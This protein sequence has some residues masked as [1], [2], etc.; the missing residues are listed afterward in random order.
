MK[1][2][3]IYL[4]RHGQTTFNVAGKFTGWMDP[5]LTKAGV[6]DAKIVARKLRDKKFGIAIHTRLKRSR[7]TLNEV[8]KFHTECG[9]IIEDDR[10]IERNYGDLNGTTHKQFIKRIGRKL[11]DLEIEGDLIANL[12]R[13]A[14][15]EAEKFLGE[16]EFELVHRGFYVP[17]P[18][19]ESFSDVEKRV[20]SFIIDLKKM[21]KK[22]RV[23]VAIAA[24]GNSIRLFR[25]IMEGASVRET[26]SWFIPYDKVFEYAV[27]V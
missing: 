22:E 20:K 16:Q 7:E 15:A 10:M 14:R 2:L 3:R 19:G 26:V 6:K 5:G 18:N 8:L 27:K 1:E 21:M 25:K 13:E 23:N 9:K 24:H 17:P 4:F 12:S 11:V